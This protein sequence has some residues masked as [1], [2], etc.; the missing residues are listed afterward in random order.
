MLLKCEQGK[1]YHML[2]AGGLGIVCAALLCKQKQIHVVHLDQI[3]VYVC[4]YVRMYVCV[5][6]SV[7]F[8]ACMYA[9]FPV[10]GRDCVCGKTSRV[11]A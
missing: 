1:G 6:L 10:R 9:V 5:C 11:A 4:I 2:A 3:N 7:C 8:Y